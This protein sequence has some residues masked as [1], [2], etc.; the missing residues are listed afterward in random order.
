MQFC[1]GELSCAKVG[2]LGYVTVINGLGVCLRR[3]TERI[4]VPK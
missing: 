4:S 3:D 2:K 1:I